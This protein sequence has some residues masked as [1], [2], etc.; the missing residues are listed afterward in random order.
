MTIQEA[1]EK[2]KEILD[3]AHQ[4]SELYKKE[5]ERFPYRLNV[6]QELHDDENEFKI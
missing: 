1:E 6:V 2:Y 4:Y 3:A 5:K